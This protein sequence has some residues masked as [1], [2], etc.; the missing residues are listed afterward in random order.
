MSTVV[1][2]ILYFTYS[3]SAA[4][5]IFLLSAI[6]ACMHAVNFMLISL[7]P[8][9]FDRYGKVG[10]ISGVVNSAVYVGSAISIWGIAFI[11]DNFGWGSTIAVWTVA[12]LIG[13]VLCIAVARKWGQ[14][15]NK[16]K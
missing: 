5:S 12:S 10:L 13:V 9:R 8:K 16:K 15:V 4:L 7:L 2:V 14:I 1:A 3:L 11:A 6:C